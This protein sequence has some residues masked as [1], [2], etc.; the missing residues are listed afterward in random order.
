MNILFL[1]QSDN[2]NGGAASILKQIAEYHLD[3]GADVYMLFLKRKQYGHWENTGYSNLHLYYGG[4]LHKFISNLRKIRAVKYDYSYNSVV[5]FTG[6]VGL[7]KRLRV[8]HVK[9]MVGRESTSIF[10]RFHGLRLLYYRMWYMVGYKAVNVLIC[11]SELMKRQLL[12]HVPWLNNTARVIVNPNPV[13]VAQMNNR[14][15][16]NVEGIPSSPFVVTAGRFI[17]EKGYDI[18]LDSFHE[19]S[20]NNS[21]WKLVILGDGSLRSE[22]EE[23]IDSLHLGEKVLL[24]GQV[25]NVFPWFKK[26][27]LCVISSR[28]EG[29]PNVLLQMMSQ[30]DKVVSTLCAGGI[31]NIP[32]LIT[33]PINDPNALCEAMNKCLEDDSTRHRELFDK[34]LENRSI[35][36]FMSRIEQNNY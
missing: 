13:N 11:Q 10:L 33:C 32:G 20:K 17:P 23:Q 31:D 34:E 18:L 21:K 2:S 7:L 1:G 29:F 6:F 15:N 12:D 25:D 36:N 16:E 27:G 9:T 8:L 26:A 4:G 28:M 19:F 24:A 35:D 30:N 14:A 22:I 5:K 3:K